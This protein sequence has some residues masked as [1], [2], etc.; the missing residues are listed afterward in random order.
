MAV[1]AFTISSLRQ[2]V[3]DFTIPYID[4]GLT[5]IMKKKESEKGLLA[6]MDPFTNDVWFLLFLSTMYVGLVLTICSKLSPYGFYGQVVQA[7]ENMIGKLWF[8]A[9][10]HAAIY[11]MLGK[12][13]LGRTSTFVI[14]DYLKHSCVIAGEPAGD[15][16]NYRVLSYIFLQVRMRWM[17]SK[18]A[19]IT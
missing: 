7:N 17:T 18:K 14:I 8:R 11:C 19:K 15:F 1:A 12:C 13:S 2:E 9:S 16:Y 3:I 10:C 5:V 4:L 6:F